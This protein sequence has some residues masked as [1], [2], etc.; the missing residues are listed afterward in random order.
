M[1]ALQIQALATRKGAT[2]S[3]KDALHRTQSLDAKE[4]IGWQLSSQILHDKIQSMGAQHEGY[5]VD[6]P[7]MVKRHLQLITRDSTTAEFFLQ[8]I[9]DS[10]A[11]PSLESPEVRARATKYVQIIMAR[12]GRED[13]AALLDLEPYSELAAFASLI[14]PMADAKGVGIPAVAEMLSGGKR[15]ELGV[16]SGPSLLGSIR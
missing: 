12:A 5:H 2:Q 4:L 3:Q 9:A 1:T 16:V 13:D 14:K 8:R 15:N 7:E 10:N 11:Y 6:Q